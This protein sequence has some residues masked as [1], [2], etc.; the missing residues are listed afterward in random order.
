[1]NETYLDFSDEKTKEE[2][3]RT[4]NSL[5]GEIGWGA[6]PAYHS[7]QIL[8]KPEESSEWS[9]FPN[10]ASMGVKV[11]K[12]KFYL[13]IYSNDSMQNSEKRDLLE[14]Q[15]YVFSLDDHPLLFRFRKNLNSLESLSTEL[16]TVKGYLLKE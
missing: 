12:G 6:S 13:D 4:I 3:S 11:D 5:L 7:S 15:G 14:K 9:I 8:V 1:M 2:Y 16:K 10:I